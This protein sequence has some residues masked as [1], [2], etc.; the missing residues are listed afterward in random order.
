MILKGLIIN[1]EKTVQQTGQNIILKELL[2]RMTIIQV[3]M[4]KFKHHLDC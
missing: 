3:L 2:K 4:L 1:L